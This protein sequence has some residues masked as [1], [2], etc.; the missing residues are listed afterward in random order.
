MIQSL[1]GISPKVGAGSF[2]APNATLIGD[3]EIG[4]NCTIWYN[5]VLRGDVCAIRIGDETNIQDGTI[6]HGT[7]K[8]CGVTLGNRVSVGH[9]VI[10]HGCTVEDGTLIGMGSIIMDLAHVP[11]QCLVGAGSLVTENSKFEP[12]WLIFG[13]P[14]RA[15]RKLNEEELKALEQSADNYLFYKTWYDGLEAQS[16]DW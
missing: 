16:V 7:Y 5:A 11:K 15:V 2:I 13:R 1:N 10:L 12:G 3:I 9:G 4:R 6:I 8:K 14:A